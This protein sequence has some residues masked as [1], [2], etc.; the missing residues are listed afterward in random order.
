MPGVGWVFLLRTPVRGPASRRSVQGGPH[1]PAQ[2]ARRARRTAAAERRGR[3]EQ[4]ASGGRSAVRVGAAA[5]A[6]APSDD[7]QARSRREPSPTQPRPRDRPAKPSEPLND[8]LPFVD[9]VGAHPVGIRGRRG[10]RHVQLARR[11]RHRSATCAATSRSRRWAI[12]LRSAHATCC[13]VGETRP[14]TVHVDR[15][16]ASRHRP[17]LVPA[18]VRQP[19]PEPRCCVSTTATRCSDRRRV[20]ASSASRTRRRSKTPTSAV[21]TD[22]TSPEDDHA[23]EAP[24]T[25]VKKAPAKKAAAKKAPAREGGGQEGPRQEG[26]SQEGTRQEGSRQEDGGEEGAGQED[27]GQEGTRQEDGGQEGTGHARHRRRRRRPRRPQ[28]R[29]HRPRRRAAKKAPAQ[30]GSGQAGHGST[31]ALN[32]ALEAPA[33][34]PRRSG[35]AFV[36]LGGSVARPSG[37]PH[38]SPARAASV[39]SRRHECPVHLHHAQ[40]QPVLPARPRGAEGHLA[41]VLP[42]RQDRRARAERL[43]QVVAA[44]DHGRHSTTTS[45]ARPASRP[46]SPSACSSRSRSSTRARTCIGNVMDGVGETATLLERYDAVLAKWADP[47]ADYEKLGERAGRAR[48]ARS[49]PPAPGTSSARSRSPWTR[50]A[51][52]PGDADVTTLSG[53][54]RR[55]VALCR[56]L[57]ARPDL[58]LLDEPTNHLD[59]E[60]VAWLERFLAE[61]R[62]HRRRHHPRSLLPRQRGPVDPRARP[63]PRHPVRGQ[64]QLV[65]RAEAGAPAPGGEGRLGPPAHARA[66]ARVGAHGTEGPA[67]QGQ[68]PPRRLREAAGRGQ[69]GRRSGRQARDR[70]PVGRAARRRR[71]R[72]R[73]PGQG[74]RRPAAHRRP[75][76]HAPPRRHRRRHRRRTA[77]ARP[78]CSG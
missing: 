65:A 76:L 10:R 9:F 1:G 7:D 63:R 59:A 6:A 44:A 62:R 60:S 12:R 40:G 41:V 78:R 77:P 53:G 31:Q 72:G 74:L 61:L 15:H 69:G 68:G 25:P 27:R 33:R 32:A 48:G 8:L 36:V 56:L 46:A 71:H 66:R 23:E 26:R 57:L 30:Q 50:C 20:R 16:P 5:L 13:R 39:T 49:R 73:A 17:A 21:V 55:R 24:V 38:S 11:L 14:F 58:L 28:P 3:A 70:H 47:D 51:L 67:G 2:R 29:R 52:P 43:R 42:G 37:R 19:V 45:P 34:T 64:L 35:G 18:G 4:A 54:E 22:T 75:Q